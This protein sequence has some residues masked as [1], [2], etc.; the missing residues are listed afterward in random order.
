MRRLSDA[1]GRDPGDD[2]PPRPQQSRLLDGVA[3][4]VLA[5]LWW[6]PQIRTGPANCAPSRATSAQLA[7]TH[8]NVVPL[9]VTRPL[10]TP[11]GQRP[12]GMLRP[13]ED[14]LTLL[15]SAG[16]TGEDALHIY[17]LLFGSCTAT[18]STSCR[19]SSSDPRKPTT[20]C[21][22]VCTGSPITE[23]PLLRALAPALASYDGA[24][25]LDRFLD[26]LLPGLTVSLTDTANLH[27]EAPRRHR[28][29][30]SLTGAPRSKGRPTASDRDAANAGAVDSHFPSASCGMQP[31]GI[32]GYSVAT[33]P[34]A[35]SSSWAPE[36]S[37]KPR[38][39]H[40]TALRAPGAATGWN[41][42]DLAATVWP[43]PRSAA[44]PASGGTR[45]H[46]LDCRDQASRGTA[47]SKPGRAGLSAQPEDPR[48]RLGGKADRYSLLTSF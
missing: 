46:L 40:R 10:A 17:R 20:Y 36:N 5:N 16:F 38:S 7:L 41:I 21:G 6:T 42:N 34:I 13:L 35:A 2:L 8:P 4:I 47:R 28:T 19:R 24:A 30:P 1:V 11:L 25:E 39:A 26:L 37:A 27:P 12:P 31:S 29:G 43:R 44:V 3:E 32:N 15:T 14:V 18:S 22:S 9:L 48:M 23:F 33:H 45:Q